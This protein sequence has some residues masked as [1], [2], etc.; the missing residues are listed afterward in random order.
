MIVNAVLREIKGPG[1]SLEFGVSLEHLLSSAKTS[2][3]KAFEITTQTGPPL[4]CLENDI[5]RHW[6]L[7]LRSLKRPPTPDVNFFLSSHRVMPRGSVIAKILFEDLFF[8]SGPRCGS[9]GAETLQHFDRAV[10]SF[11]KNKLS[12]TDGVYLHR[13]MILV[14][15]HIV[16]YQALCA[17]Y[18]DELGVSDILFPTPLNH[19]EKSN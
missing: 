15:C 14:R 5:D 17:A 12:P 11:R 18:I 1:R 6:F 2:I 4:D 3:P 16:L 9:Y 10:E 13:Q 7:F 19:G 8:G